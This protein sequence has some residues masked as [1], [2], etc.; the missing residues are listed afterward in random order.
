[1][2][3]EDRAAL[4]AELDDIQQQLKL[5][6]RWKAGEINGGMVQTASGEWKFVQL[7]EA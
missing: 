5:I 2:T 4:Q 3:T 6:E 7:N 1:M